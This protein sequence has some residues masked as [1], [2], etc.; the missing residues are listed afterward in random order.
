MFWKLLCHGNA[1]WQ[2]IRHR[3]SLRTF[4]CSSQFSSW[5]NKIQS[6][7]LF[8]FERRFMVFSLTT[9][10]FLYMV[11]YS[12][13]W[14]TVL[15][16]PASAL[17][18]SWESIVVL[19]ASVWMNLGGKSSMVW[20]I[21][22]ALGTRAC[23]YWWYWRQHCEYPLELYERKGQLTIWFKFC[24]DMSEPDWGGPWEFCCVFIPALGGP[25][26]GPE[27]DMLIERL[28]SFRV[29]LIGST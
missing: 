29:R 14:P 12:A 24:W 27:V 13:H 1:P 16:P 19:M 8:C 28:E 23:W 11:V 17:A 25:L 20:V 5:N 10:Q 26:G 18:V 22:T 21:S 2:C 9:W 7:K 3:W 15:W 6:S 4:W